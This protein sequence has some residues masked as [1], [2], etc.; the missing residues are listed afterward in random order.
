MG[1][2]S[3]KELKA[4]LKS[5]GVKCRNCV[6]KEHY[7]DKVLETWQVVPVEVSS[8]DGKIHMTKDI[9]IKQL[10]QAQQDQGE[11]DEKAMGHALEKDLD[12]NDP[13]MPEMEQIWADFAERL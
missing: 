11:S 8:P 9:F 13:R 1:K 7:I 6:E 2:K 12:K 4:I 3:S 10:M 5:K